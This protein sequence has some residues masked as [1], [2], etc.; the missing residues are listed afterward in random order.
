MDHAPL[1]IVGPTASGKTD[2]AIALAEHL[3]GELISVDSALVYRHLNIGSAKPTYPHHMIDICEPEEVYS[4]ARFAKDAKIA[5]DDITGRGKR[6][7]LVGGTMLYF[8]ALFEGL[9][10]LPEADPELRKRLAQ[11]AQREGWPAMHKELQALD[12]DGA[13]SIHPNH[14]QR[15]LRALELVMVTGKTLR[16]LHRSD[17]KLALTSSKAPVYLAIAPLKRSVLHE[18]IERRFDQM[19]ERGFLDEVRQLR[20]REGLS[21]ALPAMRAVGYRQLWQHLAGDITL[22]EARAKALAATR[23]LA[24]RQFTWL[25]K[26]PN[27]TWIHTDESGQAIM[28]ESSEPQDPSNLNQGKSKNGS[29]SNND[30]CQPK[31]TPFQCALR[32]LEGEFRSNL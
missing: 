13:A 21:D 7:I 8:R 27:L 29:K 6:V 18:R 9:N 24:K 2:L 30:E 12:P 10:P 22:P 25:R 5:I 17:G 14:S 11:Q 32:Y 15:L 31:L 20:A 19:L 26:W 28:A 1:C 16:E 4:A 23:Q 3:D